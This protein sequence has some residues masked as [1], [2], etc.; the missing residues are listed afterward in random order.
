[1]KV[2]PKVGVVFTSVE[3][4]DVD[5]DKLAKFMID[6]KQILS[7]LELENKFLDFTVQN[8][9]TAR[10]ANK[11]FFKEDLDVLLIISVIWTPDS[12]VIT[13]INNLNLPIIL[14]TT[15][16]SI[17]AVSINGAQV[18]AAT[19]KELGINF[20]FIFGELA[21]TDVQK[22]IIDYS[23][24]S[25][26]TKRLKNV[27][28]GLIGNI[29]DIMVSLST[30]LFSVKNTWGVTVVPITIP[31]ANSYIKAVNEKEINSRVEDIKKIVGKIKV[32]NEALKESVRYYYT[33]L[34]MIEGLKLDAMTL[35]C[36]PSSIKGKTCLA[37]SNLN[38]LGIMAGCE[39]D[40]N[41]TIVMYALN[42]I[43]GEA[44]M[45]SDLIYE[46]K[47]ENAI[48]FS[49]CGAGPFSCAC[50]PKDI[51]LDEHYEV[52]SGMAVYYPVKVGGKETT[53][54]NLVGNRSTYRMCILN[55]ISIPT[56]ELEYHGNPIRIK[57]KTNITELI[58]K[59]GN[60]G[61]GHHWMV[62]YGN[63]KDIFQHLCKFAGINCQLIE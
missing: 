24:A 16:I 34:K 25:A 60:E 53:I 54:I 47:K 11:I 2:K 12:T 57:F 13:L 52:K 38:D 14:Y 36:F 61:Y 3:G 32:N 15:S 30:D 50:N 37:I 29:P 10:K 62:S 5:Q 18:I 27:R 42:L 19:L 46:Y 63:H 1:M 48:M 55:G 9:E 43:T 8:T 35:N 49:H 51:V 31:D 41:S 39:G 33:F 40:I 28:I 26:I 45:N 17:H 56:E 7:T 44:P 58:N 20:N 4:Y 22:T 23:K 21:D 6:T 59:I